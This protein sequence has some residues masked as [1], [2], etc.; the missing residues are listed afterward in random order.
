MIS[1]IF[2]PPVIQIYYVYFC[3]V[4]DPQITIK[5]IT[6]I[7]TNT[8]PPLKSIPRITLD[9]VKSI[10]DLDKNTAR[11]PTAQDTYNIIPEYSLEYWNAV[12]DTAN[13]YGTNI[14]TKITKL[15][16]KKNQK[17]SLQFDLG[18]GPIESIISNFVYG[19]SNLPISSNK[20]AI[21]YGSTQFNDM[22]YQGQEVAEAVDFAKN[23]NPKQKLL[24]V[25]YDLDQKNL[26]TS[27]FDPPNP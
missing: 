11:P 22:I 6:N 23:T 4:P 16:F 7:L 26:I 21:P 25:I 8:D 3:N 9:Q 18:F 27:T 19:A 2:N 14:G 1:S 20:Q 10:E 5:D 13:S 17:L 12:Y 15:A 24:V